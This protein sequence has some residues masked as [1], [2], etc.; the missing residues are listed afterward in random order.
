MPIEAADERDAPAPADP[1][2]RRRPRRDAVRDR[3]AA[4]L[5][6]RARR[7]RGRD[8]PARRAVPLAGRSRSRSRARSPGDGLG[9]AASSASTAASA[10]RSTSPPASRRR[11]CSSA[12][13]RTTSPRP[14]PEHE[15]AASF[16]AT[17]ALLAALARAVALQR[18]L[19]RDGPPLG[20]HAEAADLRPDRRDRRRADDV[21]A[22]AARRRAQLGLPLHLDPR[23]RVLALRPAAA[24]LHRGGRGVHAL[25]RPTARATG[26]SAPAG[27][28][29][30]CT[31]STAAPS[32]PR[33]ST[34]TWSGLPRLRARCGSATRA[35]DQRQ[36]DIYGELIDSIYLYNKYGQPIYYDTWD[37]RAPDRRLAVRE[38]GPASTRASGRRAAA[39]RTSRTRG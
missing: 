19:A 14:Y 24:R 39:R 26:R 11:S 21:A 31:G 13:R 25:A 27:R 8:A 16:D 33:T 15:T 38:L 28:C 23:R 9:P 22:R 36:L 12:C 4:A 30:S 37:E 34:R 6:L 3:G 18:P 17:V 29:R 7:A 5:R 10:R 1:A 20:A 2:R 35:A 32:S